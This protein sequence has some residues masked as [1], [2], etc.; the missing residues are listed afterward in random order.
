[1]PLHPLVRVGGVEH[2]LERVELGDLAQAEPA[3]QQRDLVVA[4]HHAGAAALLELADARE[5]AAVLGAAVHEVPDA[6]ELELAAEPRLRAG[7]QLCELVVASLHVPDEH[8]LH[9]S[10]VAELW[11]SRKPVLYGIVP[12]GWPTLPA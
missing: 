4:E 12:P 6:P 1:Q 5:R 7:E 10:G 11:R 2:V 8:R 3:A 9:V